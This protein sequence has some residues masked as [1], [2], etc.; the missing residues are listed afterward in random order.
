[1]T[2]PINPQ[3]KAHDQ[4][5]HPVETKFSNKS[6]NHIV[7]TDLFHTNT[8]T[9][10]IYFIKRHKTPIKNKNKKQLCVY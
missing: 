5:P 4:W 7:E 1:M 9:H 10:L 2:W 8:E 3:T 6:I